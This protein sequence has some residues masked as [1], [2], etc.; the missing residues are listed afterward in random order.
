MCPVYGT[1]V[2]H[3]LDINK[4]HKKII[5]GYI[6][7]FIKTDARSF[8]RQLVLSKRLEFLT[9]Y[10]KEELDKVDLYIDLSG[11]VSFGI[12]PDNEL[13]NFLNNTGTKL[14]GREAVD[15]AIRK[16]ARKVFC[17][18]GFLRKYFEHRGF[19]LVKRESWNE[20]LAPPGWDYAKYHK[21]PVVWLEIPAS[22]DK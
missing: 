2:G 10:T 1:C 5:K 18:D 14:C 21:P 20:E 19:R 7:R 3:I 4:L 8:N 22:F 17:F 16:G 9:V 11:G 6:V 12:N 15:Y 13:F